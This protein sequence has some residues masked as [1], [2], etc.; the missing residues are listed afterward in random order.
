MISPDVLQYARFAADE[1]DA[2]RALASTLTFTELMF[3]ARKEKFIINRHHKLIADALDKVFRGETTR[4]AITMPPRYGKTEMA[5][6]N[7]VAKGLAHNPKSKYIHLSYSDDLALDNSDAIRDLVKSEYYQ[8][9]FPGV[10][11][12]SGS[13]SK[14][15]WYTTEGGGVYATS[16]G[17]S[18]TGF[19]AGLLQEEIEAQEAADAEL[20]AWIDEMQ[21]FGGALIIDDAIKPEDAENED[22]RNKVNRRFETTIRS[23]LNSRKTAI[24][25]IMQRLHPEDLV[26]YL[27]NIEPGVWTIL[28]IPA[29]N[30]D[31]SALWELKHS[32]EELRAME[33]R[34][35][36]TFERQYMQNPAPREGL[37]YGDFRTYE[38]LPES[39]S[40]VRS[41]TD[42]A[43]T[44]A[45]SLCTVFYKEIDNLA[46][47]LDVIHTKK[48]A[49]ETEVLVS[50][51]IAK[52]QS[53]LNRVESNN[54]GRFFM[55][56]VQAMVTKANFLRARFQAFNQRKNKE[57]RILNN[58]SGVNNYFIF[59]QNWQ[60]LFPTFY[61]EVSGYMATGKNA[62]DDAPDTL[63]G[64]YEH[65][66][67]QKSAG[68]KRK[69]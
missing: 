21:G 29:I 53:L 10:K 36:I 15:K 24:V 49:E 57:S 25:V 18:V 8:R 12:K 62:H 13:D 59:P 26:G 69:N 19:G 17:G 54:G 64:I 61:R 68:Y 40:P 33:E 11:V 46:Y 41:F 32:I 3:Q 28:S 34:D 35:R 67:A 42:V 30:E 4:L 7:A 5:V 14:K 51:L 38:T 9:L 60:R 45:D 47:V 31:G 66:Q 56:N 50:H 27:Q 58:A 55:R 43:D 52:L 37:L 1:L 48:R 6:K 63:T 44:G 65:E 20:E 2:R 22:A 39:N 16:A 23:R